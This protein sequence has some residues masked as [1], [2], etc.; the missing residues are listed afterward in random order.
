MCCLVTAFLSSRPLGTSLP[1]LFAT[2][3]PSLTART[4]A[5]VDSDSSAAT[6][7]DGERVCGAYTRAH[8]M[9]SGR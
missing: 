4:A 9:V 2:K 3:P 7:D 5:A 6:D 8:A 1:L